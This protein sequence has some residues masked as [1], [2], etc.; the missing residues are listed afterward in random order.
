M[1]GRPPMNLDPKKELQV[2]LAIHDLGEATNNE[3]SD[4][5]AKEKITF[6][7]TEL[8]RYLRRLKAKKVVVCN[9]VD[10]EEAYKLADVP[11]LPSPYL[12]QIKLK[13]TTMETKE[14]TK[15]LDEWLNSAQKSPKMPMSNKYDKYEKFEATLVTED[16][17]G[18][19]SDCTSKIGRFPR[20]AKNNLFIPPS[21]WKAWF[22]SNFY[23]LGVPDTVAKERL[24][25]RTLE[26]TNGK[27][28]IELVH[29]T[30][31]I[32]GGSG[33]YGK[34]SAGP[35]TYECLP[36]G[37]TIKIY[38]EYPLVGTVITR[39]DQL[40]R[41][42]DKYALCPKRGLGANPLHFGGALRLVKFEDKGPVKDI[43]N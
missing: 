4:H 18:G 8:N 19:D 41:V 16:F 7:K 23:T 9:I 22:R 1:V 26:I 37:I 11:S 32:H 15:V 13:L 35:K 40:E 33:S 14:A 43:L 24:T 34:G 39:A 5:L 2:M 17:I 42:I 6:E 3:L 10:G 31:I 28:P 12:G 27:K 21:W 30:A 36:P 29:R 20:D 38:F 25:F